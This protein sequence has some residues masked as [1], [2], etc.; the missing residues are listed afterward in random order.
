MEEISNK[1]LKNYLLGKCSPREMERLTAWARES[2]EHARWLFRMTDAYHA[3]R[4][5]HQVDE[6]HVQR[7][8]LDLLNRI[9]KEEKSRRHRNGVRWAMYAAAAVLAAL[10]V[11]TGLHYWGDREEMVRVVALDGVRHVLLPDSS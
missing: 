5:S 6:A 1:I 10:F 8:E 2:D 9:A 3:Y 4:A 11:M 7:A